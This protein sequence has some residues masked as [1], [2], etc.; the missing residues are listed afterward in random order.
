MSAPAA[1]KTSNP[2][3]S[4]QPGPARGSRLHLAKPV[5]LRDPVRA[6]VYGPEG[7][8]KT[9][10]A[11]DAPDPIILDVEGGSGQ[12]AIARYVFRDEPGGHVPRT[13]DEVIAAIADLT[14]TEHGFKT[15]VVDT[16]DRLEALVYAHILSRHSGK[17]GPH[18]KSGRKMDSIEDFGYGK[19]YQIALDEWRVFCRQLD[20]LRLRR[21]MNVVLLGHVSIRNFKNP[22]GE[23]YDRYTPRVQ[24]KVSGFLRE[25]PEVVGFL[26]FDEFAGK[27]NE[28]DARAKGK[29]TGRRII[30]TERTAAFDAKS[31][32]PLP[33]E[34]EVAVGHPWAPFAAAIAAAQSTSPEQLLVLITAECERIGDAALAECV[35]KAVVA[36]GADIATLTRFLR[37]LRQRA[38][39]DPQQ[40]P[41]MEGAAS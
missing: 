32:L 15:V 34:V 19:G 29:S 38:A 20:D 31:R 2:I 9:T 7:I 35:G 3:P 24:E 5:R 1:P 30:H 25:W 27:R 11:A 22:E 14:N 33:A 17:V 39:A 36:A 23:D 6:L 13:Y 41:A 16:I 40:P 21:R 12:L 18:N 26:R 4:P 10:L 28:D 37:D 8:G